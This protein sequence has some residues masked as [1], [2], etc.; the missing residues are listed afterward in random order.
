MSIARLLWPAITALVV[1]PVVA[2]AIDPLQ[3]S[4]DAL[5]VVGGLAGVVALAL[6]LLQP[7]L[8]IGNKTGLQAGSARRWHRRLGMAAGCAVMLHVVA[9][10]IY[11][12]EDIWDALLL[13]AP[14]PFSVY[15]VIALWSLLVSIG[16]AFAARRMRLATSAWRIAHSALALLI[17]A[18]GGTH[19]LMI[20]GTM[21]PI[22]KVVLVA[23]ALVATTVAIVEVNVLG[24]MR[25]RRLR[26]TGAP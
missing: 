24:P 14:T 4:R 9:L 5:W 18:C 21:E 17:T 1:W 12:P 22:S 20:D 13:E 7:L 15:G 2:A 10:L 16:L 3:R 11:S 25:L 23:C 6:L 8:A 26:Q 19:A